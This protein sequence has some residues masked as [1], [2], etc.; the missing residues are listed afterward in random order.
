MASFLLSLSLDMSVA[1]M[2]SIY[3]TGKWL[4]YGHEKTQEEELTEILKEY[5]VRTDELNKVV[6]EIKQEC[7]ELK[8]L[9]HIKNGGGEYE[10]YGEYDEVY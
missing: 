9:H 4:I 3:S 5:K 1:I 6:I 7:I 8:R 10:E 2:K